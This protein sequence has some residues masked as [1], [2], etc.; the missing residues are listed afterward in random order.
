MIPELLRDYEEPPELNRPRSPIAPAF[1]GW[2]PLVN[3]FRCD[4]GVTICIEAA[5]IDPSSLQVSVREKQVTLRGMRNVP[6]LD[7]NRAQGVGIIT[8]EI[9]PGPFE[10]TLPL[11]E[12]VDPSAMTQENVAGLIWIHLPRACASSELASASANVAP[13]SQR[14]FAT[15]R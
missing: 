10:R 6:E 13:F 8:L 11:P 1:R 12:A 9:D 14:L 15:S 7:R 4:R 5:G 2:R 3:A